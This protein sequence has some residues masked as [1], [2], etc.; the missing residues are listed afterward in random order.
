MNIVEASGLGKRYGGS[1]A[2]RDCTLEV[3]PAT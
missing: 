2:L 3:P 1:W